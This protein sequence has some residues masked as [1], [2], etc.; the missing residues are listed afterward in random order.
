[1]EDNVINLE[2][3]GDVTKIVRVNSKL[4]PHEDNVYRVH[5]D[6]GVILYLPVLIMMA[7]VFSA[8]EEYNPTETP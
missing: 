7:C 3:L 1:M 2:Q 4:F 5:F 6:T 8:A